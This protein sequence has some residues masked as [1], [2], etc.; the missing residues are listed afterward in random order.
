[1]VYGTDL[2]NDGPRPGIDQLEIARMVEAGMSGRDI[3]AAA[4]VGAARALGLPSVGSIAPG[5]DADLVL[6]DGDPIAD[7]DTL[8]SVRAV[9]RRGRVKKR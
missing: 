2:G 7:P 6:V 1:M 3:V 8:T 5:K 4:T 9:W